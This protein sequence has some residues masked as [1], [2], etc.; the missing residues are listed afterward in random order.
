MSALDLSR[1]E[2]TIRRCVAT[3]LHASYTD[4]IPTETTD[5]WRTFAAD[6]SRDLTAI[7]TRLR[8]AEARTAWQPIET[9]PMGERVLLSDGRS[10]DHRRSR[11]AGVG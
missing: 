1:Y 6:A 3:L 11:D 7:V 8:A 9:A 2:T 4:G 5:A 10:A